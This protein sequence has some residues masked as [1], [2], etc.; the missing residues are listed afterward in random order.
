MC[1]HVCISEHVST[2]IVYVP[3]CASIMDNTT[4]YTGGNNLATTLP[5]SY[6]KALVSLSEGCYKPRKVGQTLALRPSP[7]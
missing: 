2:I 1:T 3:G 4:L 7:Q 5:F 6:G